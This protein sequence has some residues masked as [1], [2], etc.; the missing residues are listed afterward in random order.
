MELLQALDANM[1]DILEGRQNFP[2]DSFKKAIIS[3]ISGQI[4]LVTRWGK[5]EMD[6]KRKQQTLDTKTSGFAV[7]N[8]SQKDALSR[9][10]SGQIFKVKSIVFEYIAFC[11][12]NILV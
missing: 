8:R 7:R 5:Q 3:Q 10:F 4:G 6:R 12:N 11:D 1:E 2:G 9:R